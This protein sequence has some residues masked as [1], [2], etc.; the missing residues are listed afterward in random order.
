[1]LDSFKIPD[2]WIYLGKGGSSFVPKQNPKVDLP[3]YKLAE[4]N[5]TTAYGLYP[6][7]D[8]YI[9][10]GTKEWNLWVEQ[11]YKIP[12]IP[13]GFVYAGGME[14]QED[15]TLFWGSTLLPL[16]MQNM[17]GGRSYTHY[18]ISEKEEGWLE[19]IK[20]HLK[21]APRVGLPPIEE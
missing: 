5:D 17:R 7:L 16:S 2:N 21:N 6:H 19:D 1:M 20:D 14:Y 3:L 10:F 4:P 15:E 13:E 18:I 9:E 12:P 8:Y 11:V